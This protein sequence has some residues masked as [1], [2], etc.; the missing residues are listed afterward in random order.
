MDYNI[1]TGVAYFA[2]L[3]SQYNGNLLEAIGGYN[4]WFRGMTVV[5]G[6][7]LDVLR[8]S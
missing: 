3:I 6:Y 2:S 8:L 1:K 4:G 5:R 7:D